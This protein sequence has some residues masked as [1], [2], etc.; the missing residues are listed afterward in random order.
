MT[1]MMKEFYIGFCRGEAEFKEREYID[2]DFAGD[3]VAGNYILR[4]YLWISTAKSKEEY[5][6]RCKRKNKRHMDEYFGRK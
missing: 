3:D 1:P 4:R 5:A 6:E 2:V